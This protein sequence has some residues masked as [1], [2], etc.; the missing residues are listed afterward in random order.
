MNFMEAVKA[1]KEGKKVTRNLPWGDVYI[2]SYNEVF[3]LKRVSEPRIEWR[4]RVC[5]IEAT[6][7]EIVDSDE[8]WNLAEEVGFDHSR[9]RFTK[10]KEFD[11]FQSKLNGNMFHRS[12]VKKCRDKIIKDIDKKCRE[13]KMVG[14]GWPSKI[15]NIVNA[16]FGDL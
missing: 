5:D 2:Y 9:T 6:D 16:R 4:M 8:D 14:L 15:L 11:P 10:L 1:M 13:E 7:W 12:D 3:Y